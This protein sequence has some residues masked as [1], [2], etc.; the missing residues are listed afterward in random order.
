VLHVPW[1]PEI[2]PHGLG[3]DSGYLHQQRAYLRGRGGHLTFY[4]L[5]RTIHSVEK[6][7]LKL[8]GLAVA[9]A[10]LISVALWLDL[11]GKVRD[12]IEGPTRYLIR[13]YGL[14]GT[15]LVMIL[16]GTALPM[17]SPLIVAFCASL[18]APL[19]P[20]A[21]VAALGYVLGLMVNYGLGYVLGLKFVRGKVPPE[22]FER[23][24]SWL[25]KWGLGLVAA[26]SF[27]PATPLETLSLLCGAFHVDARKF[28]LI[29][30]IGK[31][32]QFCLFAFLGSELAWLIWD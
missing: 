19:L 5:G 14:V 3:L 28:A 17:A 24:S 9:L 6:D 15:F 13:E 10:V 23:L 16:A 27:L 32:A 25:S 30:Y 26:F 4:A 12:E 7:R 20:L 29:S 11:W 22:R 21:L 8:V 1:V 2:I 31:A 18:G